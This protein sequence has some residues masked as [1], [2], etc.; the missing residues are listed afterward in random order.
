MADGRSCRRPYD[1]SPLRA[2][3]SSTAASAIQ[4]FRLQDPRTRA[5]LLCTLMALSGGLGVGLAMCRRIID[6]HTGR[7]GAEP[8]AHGARLIFALPGL[9]LGEAD[10][11]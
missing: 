6:A 10:E 7:I 11:R 4:P 5:Y 2:P 3:S 1:S 8:G 9:G